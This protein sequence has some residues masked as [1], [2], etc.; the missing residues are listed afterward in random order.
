[1]S[2]KAYFNI[3]QPTDVPDTFMDSESFIEFDATSIDAA[4][5]IAL[6]IFVQAMYEQKQLM[7]KVELTKIEEIKADIVINTK[8]Y[9]KETE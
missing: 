5:Y 7:T 8:I 1:M 9:L 2:Y 4:G 3:T 6:V